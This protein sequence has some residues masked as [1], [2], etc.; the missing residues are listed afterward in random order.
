[1]YVE[2]CNTHFVFVT[3]F[4]RHITAKNYRN[5]CTNKKDIVKIKGVVFSEIQ[6]RMK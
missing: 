1:M 3:N 5:W 4:L 2:K 6:R